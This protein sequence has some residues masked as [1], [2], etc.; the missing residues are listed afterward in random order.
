MFCQ[1]TYKALLPDK[2]KPREL[3]KCC[4]EQRQAFEL[5]LL[6]RITIASG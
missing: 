4:Y 1:F 6:A 3:Y 2:A 5:S